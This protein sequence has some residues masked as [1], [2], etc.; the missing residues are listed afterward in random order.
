[1]NEELGW[2]NLDPRHEH[3]GDLLR[4]DE[5]VQE[6]IRA[7]EEAGEPLRTTAITAFELYFGA[8]RSSHV[9]ENLALVKSLLSSLEV[10]AFDDEAGE[11]AA[12]IM[13]DLM[14]RGKPLDVRDIFIAAIT[15]RMDEKLATRDKN[16]KRVNGLKVEFW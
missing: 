7:Y 13:A 3:S 4:G 16:F 9:K 11:I 14:E 1:M 10:L 8:Y 2:G 15:M 12:R 5:I 6:R